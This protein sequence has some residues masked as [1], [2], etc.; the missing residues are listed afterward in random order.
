MGDVFAD[1]LD[2]SLTNLRRRPIADKIDVDRGQ[3]VGFDAY[4]QVLASDVDVVLLATPPH[5]RP[6]HL[7]ARGRGRQARLR[8]EARGGRRARRR[9]VLASLRTGQAE[10]PVGRL[11]AYAS[12][13]DGFRE[14]IQRIH[15]GAIGESCAPARQRPRGPIWTKPRQPDWTDMEWQMRNWYYFTWLSGDF[16]VEQHIHFL[17]V[18]AWVM[19]EKYPAAG[20]GHGG[21]QVRTGRVRKHFDHQP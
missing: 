3:F 21:R 16:N 7:E 15:D 17:D 8:R 12:A 18:C 4:K 10:E 19:Q 14:T 6:M 1:R 9:S 5:F 20:H 2:S 13:T 11:R